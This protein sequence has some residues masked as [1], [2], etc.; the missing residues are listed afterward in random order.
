MSRMSKV[1]RPGIFK[2]LNGRKD[3]AKEL[4]IKKDT[5]QHYFAM[6]RRQFDGITPQEQEITWGLFGIEDEGNLGSYDTFR[7]Y[8]PNVSRFE[9]RNQLNDRALHTVSVVYSNATRVFPL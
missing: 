6:E 4:R 5:I 7:K 3:N 9:G 2:Y 1:L 8:Y